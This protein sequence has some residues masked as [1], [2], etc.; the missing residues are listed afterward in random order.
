MTGHLEGPLDRDSMVAFLSA[1]GD[2]VLST[3]GPDGSPQSA[4]LTLAVTDRGELVFDAREVSRKVANLRRDGRV[5][6]V[7]GGRDGVTLQAEGL[8][9]IP[10]GDERQRCADAYQDAFPQFASSLQDSAIVVVRVRI[11]W[12]RLGDFRSPTA[13]LRETSGPI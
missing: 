2:G 13:V 6:V 3:L 12:A 11:A 5:A 7:V 4:Y 8:A 1:H 10:A 9:D